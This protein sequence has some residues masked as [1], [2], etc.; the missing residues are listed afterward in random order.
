MLFYHSLQPAST[1]CAW[2]QARSNFVP[3]SLAKVQGQTF[4]RLAVEGLTVGSSECT[5]YPQNRGEVSM[6]VVTTDEMR[7][8]EKAAE[9]ECGGEL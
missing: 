1:I 3:I 4:A 9:I 8:I 6:K 5:I 2:L 7:R